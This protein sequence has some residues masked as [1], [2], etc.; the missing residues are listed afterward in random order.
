MA[1]ESK[2]VQIIPAQNWFALVRTEGASEAEATPLSCFALY[3]TSDDDGEALQM[4]RPMGW[5]DG[6]VQFLDE[7]DGFEGLVRNDRGE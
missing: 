4:V 3:Q 5:S 7:L 2:I 6:L 1:N